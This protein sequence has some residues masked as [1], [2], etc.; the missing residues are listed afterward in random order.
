VTHQRVNARE[1]HTGS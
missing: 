1:L